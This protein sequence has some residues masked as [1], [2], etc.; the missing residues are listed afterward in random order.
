MINLCT[1]PRGEI[2]VFF[3]TDDG[4]VPFLDVAVSSLIHNAST[5]YT[6]RM[7]GNNLYLKA[8]NSNTEV[9]YS[10]KEN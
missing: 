5:E 7:S 1:A 2:P 10:K 3:T 8:A 9:K 6:Y 4:Y